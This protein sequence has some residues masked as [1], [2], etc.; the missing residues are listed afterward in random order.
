ML[1]NV[2]LRK[3]GMTAD[4]FHEALELVHPVFNE[5]ALVATCTSKKTHLNLDETFLVQS[6]STKI[7]FIWSS[8]I[9]SISKNST[10]LTDR[11]FLTYTTG[12]AI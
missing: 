4:A 9:L 10:Y 7:D 3:D 2:A 12:H 8:K 6:T 1:P 11:T 5:L